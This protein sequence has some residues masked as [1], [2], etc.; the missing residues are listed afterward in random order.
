[1]PDILVV[2]DDRHILT[3][4]KACLSREGYSVVTEDN[5]LSGLSR[6][7]E[8]EFDLII[9]DLMLPGKDGFEICREL[10]AAGNNT[11]ILI[12]TARGD[13]MDRV[14]GLKLGADDYVVKPFSVREL[15]ARVEAILRRV[16]RTRSTERPMLAAAG[17]TI[18]PE[19]RR[20]T[21]N[22]HRITLTPKEFDLLYQLAGR[23]GRVY[24]RE[25]LMEMVWGYDYAG[26]SRTVDEHI[27]NLRQKIK[28]GGATEQYIHTVWGVGYKFETG[29]RVT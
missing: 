23:P 5:G 24:T 26:S 25:E 28:D 15:T 11:P 22:E 16:N 29:E 8:K 9:L 3:L 2:E 20:V 17:I 1:M 19:S 13:E 21:V 14:L 4:L 10:L 7:Q 27:K 18:N 12:L 6:A